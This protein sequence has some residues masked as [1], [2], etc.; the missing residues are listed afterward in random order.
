[1]NSCSQKTILLVEDQVI[2]ALAEKTSLE[3]Y[4]YTVILASSG[5]IAVE[6]AH[7]T[8]DLDLILMDIDL[9]SGING[10]EAAKIILLH[11]N[12]PIVFLSCHTD[13]EVV[14]L[15]E[16]ITSYGYVVKYAGITVLDASIKMAFKLFAA[17]RKIDENERL[18]LEKRFLALFEKGPIG[19]AF[20]Q[21]IYDSSG[22]A[23]DYRFL[24]AN[25]CYQDLTGIDPRGKL[26]S[27]MHLDWAKEPGE[28][29]ETF[30]Q[31]AATG[32]HVRFERY[33]P[34]SDRWCDCVAYPYKPDHFVVSLL[35]I[36][37]RKNAELLLQSKTEILRAT[38]KMMEKVNHELLSTRMQMRA[39]EKALEE[40]EQLYR[41][42]IDSI[43]DA[44]VLLFD[45]NK[46]FLI[47]GGGEIAKSGFDRSLVEGRSLAE[48]FSTDVAELFSPLYD[49]ALHGETIAFDHRYAEFVYHQQVIPVRNSVGTVF[50]G[51]VISQNIT[52]KARIEIELRESFNKFKQL[53][54][55]MQVGVLLQGSQAEILL[56]NPMALE[57]LG[58]EEDQL[59][60][61]TSFDPAW[62]VIHEDGSPYPGSSHPVPTA[63]ATR[64]SVRNQVMGV[65]RPKSAD[66]VWLSVDAEPQLN[67]DGSVCQVVCT[68]IDISDRIRAEA[69]LRESEQNFR[70][71]SNSGQALVWTSGTD[72]LCDYFNQ[73]W[74]DFTGRS[75]EQEMGNGWAQGVHSDDL[76]T[77]LDI[78]VGSFERRESFSM[79]Y[80]LRH[81]DGDYHWLLDEGSPRYDTQGQFLGYIGHCFDITDRK[82][83]EEQIKALLAE[84]EILLRE[85]HHRIKNNM[86]TIASLLTLQAM[87]L[88]EPSAVAALADA[89]SRVQSMLLL[90]EQLFVSTG[91]SKISAQQY[92]PALATQ[93]IENFPNS[94]LVTIKTAIDDI[95]LDVKIIQPLGIII[96]EILTNIMKYAF[97]GRTAGEINVNMHYNEKRICLV[98]ADNGVGITES[99]D[100]NNSPGFGLTLISLLAKQL[101]GTIRKENDSGTKFTLEFGYLL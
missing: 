82:H 98:I 91:F 69:T 39:K 16:Q 59:L 21:L 29:F 41:I 71:L 40:S 47:V 35:E 3:E 89:G 80:R 10:A 32:E 2:T 6:L 84:K 52:E 74:L 64:N 67:E 61:S 85:V 97:I 63:I 88:T 79:E 72:M 25:L 43:P 93:V 49:R 75:L 9:G 45:H 46:R 4:G 30:S 15:T 78:Y 22:K 36:T 17:H 27:E 65:Y 20:Q 94:N 14:A 55:N 95:M 81:H 44:S 73:V 66:R 38:M 28:W 86:T 68:F 70:T 101:Q 92:I 31:V 5:E 1:M 23:I 57:L 62:N 83:A 48:A 54:R 60:G 87:S 50:A 76:Q 77:C 24:D 18:D 26:Y 42:L 12:I 37:E 99:I 100:F 90:Y 13:P 7:T 96:N 34:Q 33:F 8:A 11:R 53:V 51:L 58:L 56:S 19:I